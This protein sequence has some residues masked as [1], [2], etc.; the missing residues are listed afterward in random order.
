VEAISLIRAKERVQAS[1]AE[2]AF[3]KEQEKAAR[4]AREAEQPASVEGEGTLHAGPA[5][6]PVEEA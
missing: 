3:R 1:L 4:V 6:A 5:G 2:V